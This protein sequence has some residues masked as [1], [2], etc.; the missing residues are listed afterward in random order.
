MHRVAHVSR[1]GVSGAGKQRGFGD[2]RSRLV[3]EP[4]K[5]YDRLR[6]PSRAEN[7]PLL[8]T[9]RSAVHNV[10]PGVACFLR[11]LAPCFRA[12]K[13]LANSS[14][15]S[16]RPLLVWEFSKWDLGGVHFH[17]SCFGEDLGEPFCYPARRDK[18][19]P[20]AARFQGFMV[21]IFHLDW[22]PKKDPHKSGSTCLKCRF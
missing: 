8:M 13:P 15:T 3:E 10:W 6:R 18:R 17:D 22:P 4:F 14:P 7:P 12:R 21:V 16:P 19:Q 20:V 2:H 9:G 11:M 1:Q 5:T